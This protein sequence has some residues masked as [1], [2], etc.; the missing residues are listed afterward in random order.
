MGM[1]FYPRTYY[2]LL[3]IQSS[4]LWALLFVLRI[5]QMA[6]N[7]SIKKGPYLMNFWEYLDD[8]GIRR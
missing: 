7:G 2:G 8:Q 4:E 6:A 5:F 3:L 1:V